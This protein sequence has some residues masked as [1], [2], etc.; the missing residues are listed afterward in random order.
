MGLGSSSSS[1]SN[2]P[3]GDHK[4]PALHEEL[5]TATTSDSTASTTT[6]TT[7]TATLRAGLP[8]QSKKKPS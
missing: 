3:D 7:T 8:K 4:M 5:P 2:V 1:S 6:T